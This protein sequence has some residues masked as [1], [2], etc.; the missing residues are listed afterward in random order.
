[1]RNYNLT[2]ED[3]VITD[4]CPLFCIPRRKTSW[5]PANRI[6]KWRHIAKN[7]ECP[8]E[9]DLPFLVHQLWYILLCEGS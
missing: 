1:M 8:R 9:S 3:S 5:L 2:M 4:P 6:P 7:M